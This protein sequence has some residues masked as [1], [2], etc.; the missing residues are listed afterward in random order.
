MMKKIALLAAVP[1]ILLFSCADSN[2]STE[3]TEAPEEATSSM[4][5]AHGGE[6]PEGAKVDPVC[7][8]FEEE[9]AWT[10]WSVNAADTVWF[11]SPVCKERY[12]KDPS[13]YPQTPG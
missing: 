6:A 2:S 11:C 3:A 7:H 10:D 13:Q 12:D 9:I 4:H 1:A 8:M 5:H